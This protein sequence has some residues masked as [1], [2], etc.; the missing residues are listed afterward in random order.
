MFP[1]GGGLVKLSS[2]PALRAA[3]IAACAWEASQVAVN[4]PYTWTAGAHALRR[5]KAGR[6]ALSALCGLLWYHLVLEP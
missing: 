3:V 5:T 2:N 6:A 4:G 1:L